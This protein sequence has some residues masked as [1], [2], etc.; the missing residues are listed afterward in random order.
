[1]E[2]SDLYMEFDVSIPWLESFFALGGK[3][4]PSLF[5]IMPAGEHWKLRG[6][7]PDE[8]HKMQVR[9]PLPQKWAGLLD[10]DLKKVSG[11]SGAIFLS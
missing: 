6:I 11:I 5:V 9:V 7:P 10:E 1:M 8:Q 3:D 2:R 4:H